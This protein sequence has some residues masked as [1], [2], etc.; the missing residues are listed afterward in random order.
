MKSLATS[1][2]APYGSPSSATSYPGLS[3]GLRL[4]RSGVSCSAGDSSHPRG[5]LP[6]H[7]PHLR[8]KTKARALWS[9]TPPIRSGILS[10]VCSSGGA[11]KSPG[12]ISPPGALRT[13][14]EPLDS[15]GSHRPVVR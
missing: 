8:A 14:R 1:M 9:C 7:E 15:P 11:G 13:R 5:R 4:R 12:G 3:P 6:R 2:L 10:Q